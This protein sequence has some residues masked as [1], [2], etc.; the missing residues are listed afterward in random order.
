M[1]L[2]AGYL[3]TL[4]GILDG[5]PRRTPAPS[6]SIA[7]GDVFVPESP[8]GRY[9]VVSPTLGGTHRSPNVK[10]L[11]R[12]A[13]GRGYTVVVHSRAGIAPST[14]SLALCV[15]HARAHSAHPPCVV[16][17]SMGAYEVCKLRLEDAVVASVSNAYDADRALARMN[18]ISRMAL[19][20]KLGRAGMKRLRG[21]SCA[22][23]ISHAMSPTLLVN[24]RND[25]VVPESCVDMGASLSCSN[26]LV[27]SSTYPRGGHVSFLGPR[28]RRLAFEA[29]L[30]FFD[31]SL[32]RSPPV[33]KPPRHRP[34]PRT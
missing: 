26:P 7:C 18:P 34:G 25:P 3:D 10:P 23:E 2:L 1:R 16:G 6:Y 27:I 24:S 9:M 31:D 13:L 15:D 30:D 20:L 8:S 21:A 22:D 32:T 19:R 28:R 29:A 17:L 33:P 5:A 12:E 11:V 14:A 4:R